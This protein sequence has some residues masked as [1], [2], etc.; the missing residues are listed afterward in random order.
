MYAAIDCWLVPIPVT[1][2]TG[3]LAAF[4]PAHSLPPCFSPPPCCRR[5]LD[6]E[7]Y[8]YG[9][10]LGFSPPMPADFEPIEIENLS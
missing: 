4:L 5:A 10:A 3:N 8:F 2:P 6:G 1:Y 7:L 9:R